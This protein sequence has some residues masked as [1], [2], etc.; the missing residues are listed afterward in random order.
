MSLLNWIFDL[1]QHRRLED[2]RDEMRR[3]RAQAASVHDASGRVDVAR[4]ELALG[5][6]ALAV[7]TLQRM[8]VEKGLCTQAE[9]SD[10]LRAIDLEDGR[11]DNRAPL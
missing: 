9:F 2:L 1:Y 10:K 3:E 4:L 6:L 7:K 11:A 5:E 8:A